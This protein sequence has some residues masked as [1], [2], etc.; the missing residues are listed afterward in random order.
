MHIR[1]SC[2]VFCQG[3]PDL[4]SA[5]LLES[6]QEVWS[7]HLCLCSLQDITAQACVLERHANSFMC[8]HYLVLTVH[9]KAQPIWLS[10]SAPS[11]CLSHY[12]SCNTCSKDCIWLTVTTRYWEVCIQWK[13]EQRKTLNIISDGSVTVLAD[14]NINAKE[15]SLS[16]N[17]HRLVRVAFSDTVQYSV[18]VSCKQ[19]LY[20]RR[21]CVSSVATC[22]PSLQWQ[23][24][25]INGLMKLL[26]LQS[27]GWINSTLL[28]MA[29]PKSLPFGRPETQ[30]TTAPIHITHIQHAAGTHTHTHAGSATENK[31]LRFLLIAAIYFSVSYESS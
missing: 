14:W 25:Q 5:L 24:W 30:G 3:T 20:K 16:W 1:V 17:E 10:L 28:I 15:N 22:W 2:P 4:N 18:F 13:W 23:R 6:T 26:S 12:V 27:G 9:R 29:P 7:V 8:L 11:T 19:L 31:K 21:W